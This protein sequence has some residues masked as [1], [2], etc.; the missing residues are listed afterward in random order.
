MKDGCD[1]THPIRA[2]L[3]LFESE[4]EA[5]ASESKTIR[6]SMAFPIISGRVPS[7]NFSSLF[8]T[9]IQPNR[10]VFGTFLT[11]FRTFF[12]ACLARILDFESKSGFFARQRPQR[13]FACTMSEAEDLYL[14]SRRPILHPHPAFPSVHQPAPASPPHLTRH[15]AP[16]HLSPAVISRRY[17]SPK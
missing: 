2:H 16:I 15:P 13:G 14:I 10:A 9:Q 3:C 1:P 7:M 4:P 8:S 17:V 6:G 12:D 11:V 5:H